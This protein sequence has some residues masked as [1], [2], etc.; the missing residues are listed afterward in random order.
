MRV[1]PIRLLKF[2]RKGYT[3]E[4]IAKISEFLSVVTHVHPGAL[5]ESE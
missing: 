4:E 2:K 5:I 1:R 3:N